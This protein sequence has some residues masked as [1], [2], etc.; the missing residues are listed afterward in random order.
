[1]HFPGLSHEAAKFL[2]HE[3]GIL[4]V[5][6]DTMSIEVGS[7]FRDLGTKT[8]DTLSPT[9]RE[10]LSNNVWIIENVGNKLSSLP[11]K[12]FNVLA[13]LYKLKNATGAPARTV[14]IL[15]N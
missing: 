8:K 3:R 2:V 14:A 4:G 13:M 11:P 6:I 12:G 9:H 15:N 1:M 10:L 7:A 5:G